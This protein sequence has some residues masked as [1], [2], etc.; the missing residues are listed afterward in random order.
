VWLGSAPDRFFSLTQ[1]ELRLDNGIETRRR[2]FGTDGLCGIVAGERTA[3]IDF[4]VYANESEATKALYQS[5]RLRSPIQ[6]M[7]QLGHQPGQLFGAYLKSV[8]L[9]T[10]DFDDAEVRLRWKFSGCRAQGAADDELT[11]AFG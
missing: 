7:L 10:P 9:E 6:A 2:E 1:A 3:S 5:A 11:I 4:E 8:Q